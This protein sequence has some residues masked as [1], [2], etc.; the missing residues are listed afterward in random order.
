MLSLLLRAHVGQ[1]EEDRS[2][3]QAWEWNE[4]DVQAREW[5]TLTSSVV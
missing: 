2:D 1:E 3:D 4:V 5:V